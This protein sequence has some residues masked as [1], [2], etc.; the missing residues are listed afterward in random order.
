[1][2]KV[3]QTHLYCEEC[4]LQFDKKLLF[5]LHISLKH[6][7]RIQ[8]VKEP[9]IYI[10]K[11]LKPQISEK[12]FSDHVLVGKTCNF[13][14]INSDISLHETKSSLKIHSESNPREEKLFKCSSCDGSFTSKQHLKNHIKIAHECE[15][16]FECSICGHCFKQ[17]NGLN[18]HISTVHEKKKP[19][20]CNTCYAKL[21]TRHGLNIHIA[22]VHKGN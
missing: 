11:S 9:E 3:V 10:E 16:S 21:A 19:F 17:K 20:E 4:S 13:E 6:R 1:M 2:E 22:S 7:R 14:A 12:S 15:K 5:D 8:V 18:R